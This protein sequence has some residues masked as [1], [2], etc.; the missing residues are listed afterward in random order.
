MIGEFFIIKARIKKR[1]EGMFNNGKDIV[2]DLGCGDNPHYYKN[3]KGNIVCLDI[4]KS[5]KTNIVADADFLPLKKNSF[6]KVIMIN[7]LYYF[8][9]PLNVLENLCPILK[10]NGKLIII[11]PFMYPIHDAPDDKYRFTEFGLNTMLQDNFKVLSIEPVGGFFTLPSVVLHSII[12]GIPLLF[13][14]DIGNFFQAL[15]YILWPLYIAAQLIGILD[16][17]DRTRRWPVYY[18]AVAQK[19]S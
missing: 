10:K 17:L 8:K 3:I 13:P 12:K 9:N 15:T 14:K 7:S 2:L 5:D 18:I 4:I 6:D 1:L 16:I 19:K 11:V